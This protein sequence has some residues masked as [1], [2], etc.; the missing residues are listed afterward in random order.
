MQALH[1]VLRHSQFHGGDSDF[2]QATVFAAGQ[3]GDPDDEGQ[4][5]E[6]REEQRID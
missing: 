2:L 1:L 6:E 5:L 4:G 3:P